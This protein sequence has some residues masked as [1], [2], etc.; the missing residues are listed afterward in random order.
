[1]AG[2]RKVN[3]HASR[4]LQATKLASVCATGAE[5]EAAARR[6]GHSPEMFMNTYA[7]HSS[8]KT[9]AELVK[10]IMA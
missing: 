5:L 10:R 3:P 1:M 8:D 4:H 7:K 6:L 9:E 2:V